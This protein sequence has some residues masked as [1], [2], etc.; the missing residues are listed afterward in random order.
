MDIK[1]YLICV[2]CAY[3]SKC[4]ACNMCDCLL[5]VCLPSPPCLSVRLYFF[6]LKKKKTAKR[7]TTKIFNLKYVRMSI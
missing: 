5:T 6:S 2:V 1:S 7:Q 4:A 3:V